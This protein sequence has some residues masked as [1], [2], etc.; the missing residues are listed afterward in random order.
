MTL[1]RCLIILAL[2]TA[3]TARAQDDVFLFSFFRGNGEAGVYLATSDDGRRFTP[4]NDDQPVMAPPKWENQNLTR[5]PSIVY[6]DGRFHMVWTS[7]W[8]G[9]VFGYATSR[10]LKEWSEPV[11]AR[12]FPESLPEEDQPLNVWAPEIHRDPVHDEL[13]ILFSSTTPR[14]LN[15]D[16]SPIHHNLDHRTYA[17]RTKDGETF[18]EARKFFD[19]GFSVIDPV[20]A[21]D[22]QRDRWAM[23][24]KH[25]LYRESG[26]KNVRMAFA[27]R[28]LKAPFPPEFTELSEPIVGPGAPIRPRLQVEG[29][30]LFRHGGRWLLY[31]DAFTSG[32]YVLATS[33]DLA[34]W[35]DET[36]DLRTPRGARHGTIFTAPRE[37]VAWLAKE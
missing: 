34:E 35:R 13:L 6:H 18:T 9:S 2:L 27:P 5:D 32:R 30:S 10:D 24:L 11:M 25:E 26:G 36:S 19:P 14:E 16:D 20:L 33:A 12:P 21:L 8:E 29:P 1:A 17:V 23:A 37:A 22:E 4:L 3:G 7:N 28:D 15:D 31:A